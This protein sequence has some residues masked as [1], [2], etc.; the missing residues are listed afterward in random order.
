MPPLS[1]MQFMNCV[2]H[3]SAVAGDAEFLSLWAYLFI[4]RVRPQYLEVVIILSRAV[5]RGTDHD[6]AVST[7]MSTFPNVSSPTFQPLPPFLHECLNVQ[8]VDEA[9]QTALDLDGLA[10]SCDEFCEDTGSDPFQGTW[11]DF[12]GKT[13][14]RACDVYKYVSGSGVWGCSYFEYILF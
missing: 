3:S 9:E 12:L 8:K 5:S 1:V 6:E 7:R 11:C 4:Q 13:G 14:C 10:I 2:F